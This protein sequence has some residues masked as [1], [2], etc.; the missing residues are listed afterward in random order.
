MASS[1]NSKV[2]RASRPA[3]VER[4]DKYEPTRDNSQVDQFG[5]I[6]LHEAFEKGVI[7][8]TIEENEVSYNSV[9]DPGS[10]L[11]RSPD[12]FDSI[13]KAEYVRNTLVGL[14]LN[15]TERERAE[16]KVSEALSKAGVANETSAE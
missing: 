11:S 12:V 15:K 14:E 3:F 8:S 6:N 10:L 16:A 9:V 2:R 13:R 1:N 4:L 5:F 7:P